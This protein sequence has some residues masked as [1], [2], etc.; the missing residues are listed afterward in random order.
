MKKT[1]LF[2]YTVIL[3]SASLLAACGQAAAVN[4]GSPTDVPASS[5]N[6]NPSA[7]TVTPVG[8]NN[9]SSSGA[10]SDSKYVDACVLLTK[11][12]VSM[13]LGVPVD[14][15]TS[16]GLGGVCTYTT[17]DKSIEFTIAGHTGGKK[18]F[19]TQLERLG[20]SALVIPGLGDQA[21][22]NTNS[23]ALFLLKGDAEYMFN[24]SDLNFQPLA[25]SVI[26][27]ID[28]K[29]AEQLLKNLH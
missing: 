19:A 15:A 6:S 14:S 2:L 8:A 4:P 10:T 13:A 29:V 7:P 17:A 3:A 9:P 16:T 26:Q 11:E 28:T 5:P 1:T 22:F 27:D 12:D 24:A 20:D 18:A 25:Q 23:N 21:L